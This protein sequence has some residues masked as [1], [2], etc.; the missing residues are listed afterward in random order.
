MIYIDLTYCYSR[1]VTVLADYVIHT[2]TSLISG[3]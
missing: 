3:D 2:I 1:I